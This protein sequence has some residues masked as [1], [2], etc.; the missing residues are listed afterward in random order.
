MTTVHPRSDAR[1]LLKEVAT[2]SR[3]LERKV[4]LFVQDG[5]GDGQSPEGAHIVDTGRPLSRLT[6]MTKGAARMMGAVR[7]RRAEI[8]QFHDPELLPWAFF[9][10]FMGM[11]VVYDVHEDVPR[12][13]LHNPRL[14]PLAR[15]A[16]SPM[17]SAVEWLAGRYLSGIVAA[18]PEI[19][20]RFPTRKT[21]LV[22]NYPLLDEFPPLPA[23]SFAQREKAF[24]YIGGLTRV[25]GLFAMTEAIA[26]LSCPEVKL[27][28][29]GNFIDEAEREAVMASSAGRR[30]QIEGWLDRTEVAHLLSQ[31]QAGLVVLAPIEN[32][33]EARPVKLFEYMAAGLPVIASDFPRWRE[34]VEGAECGLL[35]D[36]TDP[37]AIAAAMKWILD[38][39]L[40]AQAMGERGRQAIFEQYNWAPEGKALVALYRKLLA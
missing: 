24:A 5:A 26:H 25:R 12:Q 16:L 37:A 18:T 11:K 35:V 40:E 20:R 7:R 13:I 17:V 6:R 10:Q 1:I 4:Y 28:L 19:A 38:N 2:L 23:R 8:V 31:V 39:P 30:L 29:A 15:R 21:V 33:I 9:L 27:R 36:P 32:Y 3:S 34:I 14:A 22:R